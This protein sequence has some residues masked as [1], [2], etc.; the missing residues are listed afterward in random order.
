MSEIGDECPICLEV[1]EPSDNRVLKCL[2]KYHKECIKDWSIRSDLCPLCN[3]KIVFLSSK[4]NNIITD[5]ED[6]SDRCINCIIS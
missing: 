2:H 4:S 5:Y 3:S 1:L 6:I